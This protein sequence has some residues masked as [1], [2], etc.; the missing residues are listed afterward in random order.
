MSELN[1]KSNYNSDSD[2][3][4][5]ESPKVF[6]T[7]SDYFIDISGSAHA[8]RP[9]AHVMIRHYKQ[10]ADGSSQDVDVI[11][12]DKPIISIVKHFPNYVKVSLDFGNNEDMDLRMTWMLLEQ[13]NDPVNS[14][15]YLPEEIEKGYYTDGFGN[16]KQVYFPMLEV[17]LSPIGRETQYMIHCFNPL[18]NALSPRN[19]LSINPCVLQ[20]T[21]NEELIV[22]NDEL[23]D[24]DMAELRNEVMEEYA[25]QMKRN[26]N[27]H[28]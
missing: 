23:E 22:I 28:G 9:K 7:D 13:Y 26:P 27:F 17:I 3:R 18:I 2:I 6:K 16:E 21:F 5:N 24:V 4:N 25:E 20:F 1:Y 14:V 19:P 12:F 8:G 11:S 15:S 10:Y